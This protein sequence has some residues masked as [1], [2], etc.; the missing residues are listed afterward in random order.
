MQIVSY[1]YSGG[2]NMFPQIMVQPKLLNGWVFILKLLLQVEVIHDIAEVQFV[3]MKKGR[4]EKNKQM[5]E[6]LIDP[7]SHQRLWRP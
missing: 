1:C 5:L 7:I 2:T 3:G 4:R 6:A